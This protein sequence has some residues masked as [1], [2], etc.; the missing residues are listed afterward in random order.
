MSMEMLAY[1][2]VAA[3]S[4]ALSLS[5]FGKYYHSLE[6]GNDAAQFAAFVGQINSAMGYYSSSFTA[7]VPKS[8]CNST[9]H[10]STVAYGNL[11]FR[12]DA[13]IE[14]D[15]GLCSSAGKLVQLHMDMQ[16]NGTF[17]IR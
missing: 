5:M 7:L 6:Y 15:K 10:G 2:A 14:V 9:I 11:T 8:F 12:A 17:A 1:I 3:A 16:S 4:L 13:A